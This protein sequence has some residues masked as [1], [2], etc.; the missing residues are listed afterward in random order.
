MSDATVDVK[1][2]EHEVYVHPAMHVLTPILALAATWVVR[3]ALSSAY[4][5]A[6]GRTAPRA[7]DPT[8]SVHRAFLWA[9][10]TAAAVAITEVAIYRVSHRMRPAKQG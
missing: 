4:E 1:P 2:A 7:T 9:G 6:T 3:K 8:V 10:T 5:R